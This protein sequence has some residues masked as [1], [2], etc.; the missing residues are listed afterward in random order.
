M[1][2]RRGWTLVGSAALLIVAGALVGIEELYALA[3]AALVLVAAA[4]AWVHGRSWDLSAERKLPSRV[5]AGCEARV[6]LRVR[7]RRPQI[8][9]V[10]TLRD[11][12]GGGRRAASFLVAPLR[13]GQ[14][15]HGAYRLPTA[16][17]GIFTLGPLELSLK[18]PFGLATYRRTGAPAST[19]TIHPHIDVIP[20]PPLGA[21]TDARPGHGRPRL[22]AQGDEFYALRDYRTGDDLRRVHWAATARNDQLMIRQEETTHRGRITVAMDLRDHA[23]RPAALET[24]L[25]AA[26]SVAAA[27]ARAGI[28]VRLVHTGGL[29][30]GFAGRRH[31]TAVLDELALAA[32]HP[33]A[34]EPLARQL[35]RGLGDDSGTV[36]A[37]TSDAADDS[38]LVALSRA[39]GRRGSTTLVV[40]ER[41]RDPGV[42]SPATDHFGFAVVWVAA[43]AAFAPAWCRAIG[44]ARNRESG[45]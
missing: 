8:S 37:F 27:G 30:T 38:E 44:S 25:S 17:R 11:P 26:A 39:S 21:G 29:D 4:Y 19:L 2:T 36:V 12:F 13:A 32:T 20:A 15:D 28:D 31:H 9:P 41:E 23:W 3:G 6:E 34:G 7:N 18:D 14:V 16:Q 43:G 22:G 35:R 45:G 5:A 24:A 1:L 10:V 33:D 40:I 42:P